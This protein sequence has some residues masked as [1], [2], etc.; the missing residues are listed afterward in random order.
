[1]KIAVDVMGG[2]HAPE[3]VIQG[4]ERARDQWSDLNFNIAIGYPF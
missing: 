4:I 3:V 2:D 1:M